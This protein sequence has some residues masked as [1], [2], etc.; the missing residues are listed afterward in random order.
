MN[1]PHHY[2]YYLKHMFLL[3]CVHSYPPCNSIFVN[4]LILMK[5]CEVMCY[6]AELHAYYNIIH[7]QFN[8]ILNITISSILYHKNYILNFLTFPVNNRLDSL[9]FVIP[10]MAYL[11]QYYPIF[12]NYYDQY[13]ILI[14]Y[15]FFKYF[16]RIILLFI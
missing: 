10:N 2:Y 5:M 12:L 7:N 6:N 4:Y 9:D 8:R 3:V 15:N 13:W 14:N 11:N 1:E 16:S